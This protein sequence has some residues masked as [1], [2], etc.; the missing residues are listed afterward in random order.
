[1]DS[2]IRARTS[3]NSF[4]ATI[5]TWATVQE[6]DMVAGMEEAMEEEE[7]VLDGWCGRNIEFPQ[8]WM[9]HILS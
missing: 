9:S 6:V 4:V 3:I 2:R 5:I 1:M 8:I 7:G